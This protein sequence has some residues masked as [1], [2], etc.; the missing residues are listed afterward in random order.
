[1][2]KMTFTALVLVM[3]F[4]MTGMGCTTMGDDPTAS[5][6]VSGAA[7]G[8]L[9]GGV[10]GNNIG[11]LNSAEGAVA[12]ALV[13]GL[14]GHQSGSRQQTIDNQQAQISSQQSQINAVRQ[15]ASTHVVNITNSNG[16]ITPVVLHREGNQWRGPRGELYNS[17]PTATQLKPYYG[18]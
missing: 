17:L 3:A 13:G 14:L 8:A 7:L 15:E 6:T 1:M 10:A 18:L 9:L 5:G 12:G 4:M 11:G 16:S 2:R